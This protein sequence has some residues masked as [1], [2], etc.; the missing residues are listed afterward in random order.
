MPGCVD[1]AR[2]GSPEEIRLEVKLKLA[3]VDV[4]FALIELCVRQRDAHDHEVVILLE[5]EAW[6]D[7]ALSRDCVA[8]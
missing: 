7:H 2:G 4:K 5:R 3:F 1:R 8:D 6:G